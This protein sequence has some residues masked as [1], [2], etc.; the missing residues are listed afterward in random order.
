MKK[1]SFKGHYI[2]GKFENKASPT[3]TQK[4]PGDFEDQVIDFP[5]SFECDTKVFEYG[6]MC[7]LKWAKMGLQKRKEL[8]A[9]LKQIFQNKQED[10]SEIISRETGKPLWESQM[11]V[12]AVIRKIDITL[13]RAVNRIQDQEIQNFKGDFV[14]RIRFKS[15]GLL[16]V[17]GPFNFPMHV[18]FSQIFAALL[19]GNSVIFKP[20]EKTPACGQKLT[21]CLADLNLPVGVFQMLQGDGSFSQK[22]VKHPSVDGILFVGSFE[23]GQKIKEM[24]L[25]DPNKFLA[26]EMGGHNSTLIWDYSS[27]EQV[28]LETLKSCFWTTGQRCSST[29]QILI[30]KKNKDFIKDFIKAVQEIKIGHW[31]GNPFMGPLIDD[32]S[33]KRAFEFEKEMISKQATVLQKMQDRSHL[34]GYY[35]SP[36]V[37]Q[38]DLPQMFSS[39]AKEQ[40]TPQVCIYTVDNLQDAVK[41]INHSGYGLAL[42]LFS[43]DPKIKEEIFYQAKV[44]LINYNKSS[45]GASS[46]LPFGGVGKSGNHRPGGSFMIDS[47]VS[48]LAE[49]EG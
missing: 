38:M 41:S 12:Q 10:L 9:P 29:S 24:T 16:L 5:L 28:I 2:N 11:E 33:F 1:I 49:Q 46:F 13:K 25:N 18:S 43:E 7:H 4:S 32:R 19:S 36:G 34:K 27:K 30:H 42:S 31:K 26:L 35:V 21:E 47:C 3:K 15:H 40:F 39:K 48:I 37:Y 6:K 8:L 20:S 23:V 45:C 22:L 14:G 44:G 17:I